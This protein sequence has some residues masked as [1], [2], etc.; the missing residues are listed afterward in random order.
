MVE[1]KHMPVALFTCNAC[2]AEAMVKEGDGLPPGWTSGR[3]GELN[4][5]RCQPCAE[6]KRCVRHCP[7]VVAE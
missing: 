7:R 4:V 3:E 6:C 1:F 2:G 5:H